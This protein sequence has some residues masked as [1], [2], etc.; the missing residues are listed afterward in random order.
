[1]LLVAA[2]VPPPSPD[3]FPE[4]TREVALVTGL[5]LGDVRSRLM[6][7]LPRV[8]LAEADPD[9]ARNVAAALEK[10]GVIV[11]VCDPR[12]APGDD[13]RLLARSLDFGPGVL[14]VIDAAG[15]RE[16]VPAS[17]LFL[18]QR[19]VRVTTQTEV[20]KKSERRVDLTRAVLTGGLLLTKKVQTESRRTT[21]TRDR[22][23][24]LHRTDGGRDVMIYERRVD[25][26]FLGADFTPSSTANFDRLIARL[27]AFAPRVPH[28]DRATHPGVAS[29]LPTTPGQSV[30]LA[31]WLVLL[32]HVRGAPAQIS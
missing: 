15:E 7:P 27:A 9:R 31:L 21:T 14:S 25:Y 26:R 3:G 29:S 11:L 12:A 28:D 24:L 2:Q 13:D 10:L 23:L 4:G 18:V 32:A 6:G 22:F 5:A 30:D 1:M 17:S 20:T 8:L 19:G 16:E